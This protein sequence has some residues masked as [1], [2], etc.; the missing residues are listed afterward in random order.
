MLSEDEVVAETSIYGRAWKPSPTNL[1]Q[2]S[3]L[4][5]N[6]PLSLPQGNI[7]HCEAIFHTEGISQI[8]KEFISL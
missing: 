8:P 2:G 5:I 7:S 6:K 4:K 3:E 1:Y